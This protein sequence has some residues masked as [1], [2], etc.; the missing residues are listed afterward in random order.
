MKIVNRLRA[1]WRLHRP[2]IVAIGF[3]VVLMFGAGLYFRVR[4]SEA[5]ESL[6]KA[7]VR[8]WY[9]RQSFLDIRQLPGGAEILDTLVVNG[10][11]SALWHLDR[12]PVPDPAR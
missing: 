2:Y 9:V 8:V 4:M 11:D 6:L 7:K 12:L 10:L 1:A 5:S 3:L